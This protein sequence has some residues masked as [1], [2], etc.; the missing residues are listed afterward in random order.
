MLTLIAV[1][2]FFAGIG[3]LIGLLPYFLCVSQGKSNLGSLALT[4]CMISAVLLFV[5]AAALGL[6][7]LIAII[8][9]IAA[10]AASSDC[11]D[12]LGNAP[13]YREDVGPTV[14]APRTAPAPRTIPAPGPA[15]GPQFALR[16]L[17][18]PMSGR[19][20]RLGT[21]GIL[22]GRESDC[23]IRFFGNAP[24][25]SRHHCSV[26]IQHGRP[27]L[28]DLGSSYGSYLADGTKLP[29]NYPMP[30]HPGSKFY[31]G[32]SKNLFELVALH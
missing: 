2:L 19:T 32:S 3:A 5:D 31:L 17:S 12:I 27:A 22:I 7:V 28:V 21:G 10:F 11:D 24:G 6:T 13:P 25:V 15:L 16:C 30:I 4:L 18:G 1:A 14:P 23:G 26:R 29:P 20:Y 9:C 8:F